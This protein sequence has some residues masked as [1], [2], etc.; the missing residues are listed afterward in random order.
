MKLALLETDVLNTAKTVRDGIEAAGA[1][2]VKLASF[3]ETHSTEITSLAALAGPGTAGATAAGLG[4]LNTVI[5]AVKDAGTAAV[6][7][8]LSVSFDAAAITEVKAVIT[9]LEKA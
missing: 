2:A 7:N 5:N 8:G 1:D 4:L 3:L 9:A 6:G